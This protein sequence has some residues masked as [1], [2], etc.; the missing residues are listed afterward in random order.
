M[1]YSKSYDDQVH[2]FREFVCSNK[3]CAHR[4][5][6]SVPTD[7]TYVEWRGGPQVVC[8]CC[9]GHQDRH[10]LA[11]VD[12]GDWCFTDEVTLTDDGAVD[13]E[14][15]IADIIEKHERLQTEVPVDT[16]PP[17]PTPEEIAAMTP[18]SNGIINDLEDTD[19]SS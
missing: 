7:Q 13:V 3:E 14:G 8:P 1:N 5:A 12:N 6:L 15:P 9:N 18:D 16:Y 10:A 2:T 4:F 19:A 17:V 11:V